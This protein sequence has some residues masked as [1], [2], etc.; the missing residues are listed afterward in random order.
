MM[1]KNVFKLALLPALVS[2]LLTLSGTAMAAPKQWALVSDSVLDG[3]ID[4]VNNF[5]A[6][7]EGRIFM[8]QFSL[9][10]ADWPEG[11]HLI[12]KIE[13]VS[14]AEIGTG[15]KPRV[16]MTMSSP[17]TTLYY[18]GSQTDVDQY[19]GVWYS[20][21]G[22]SGDFLISPVTQVSEPTVSLSISSAT[23]S[24]EMMSPHDYGASKAI[25]GVLGDNSTNVW[26]SLTNDDTPTLTLDMGASVQATHYRLSR[27]YCANAPGQVQWLA[28]TWTVEGSND[29]AT[30]TTI[31]TEL[32]DQSADYPQNSCNQ[33]G[34]FKAI[35]VPDNY[36]YYRFNLRDKPEYTGNGV[37]IAEIELWN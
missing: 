35:D 29:G 30:W 15:S 25:D 6:T 13:P 31:D 21:D 7:M 10:N 1:K 20:A 12:G 17:T 36:R 11:G 33:W 16:T 23:A 32:T 2:T 14:I 5:Q 26:F 4:T 37:A 28:V 8:N 3:N 24:T 18:L 19:Q 9:V 34:P 27:G 22:E